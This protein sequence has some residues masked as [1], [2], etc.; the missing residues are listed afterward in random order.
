MTASV[1]IE[2]LFDCLRLKRGRCSRQVRGAGLLDD[3]RSKRPLPIRPT[4]PLLAQVL[5]S[6]LLL[7][8][9]ELSDTKVY[10]P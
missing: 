4:R 9:L 7:S 5:S 8:S 3:G 2:G 1:W 10:A 6:S